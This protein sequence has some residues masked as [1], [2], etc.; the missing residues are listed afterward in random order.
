MLNSLVRLEYLQ[1][2]FR[3]N[4]ELNDNLQPPLSAK[5]PMLHILH[6]DSSRMHTPHQLISSLTTP[7]T[8]VHAHITGGC[9][10]S[11]IAQLMN[12]LCAPRNVASLRT[13]TLSFAIID[14]RPD[15]SAEHSR[16]GSFLELVEPLLRLHSLTSLAV[17]ASIQ[18]WGGIQ[19]DSTESVHAQHKPLAI[20]DFST[21]TMARAWPCLRQLALTHASGFLKYS[22]APFDISIVRPS[23]GALVKLA[24]ECPA[25]EA[26]T[27]HVADVDQSGLESLEEQVEAG[28]GQQTALLDIHLEGDRSVNPDDLHLVDIDRLATVLH[29]LFPRLRGRKPQPLP[30][31]ADPWTGPW[32]YSEIDRLLEKLYTL[33]IGTGAA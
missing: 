12:A 2:T 14:Q 28:C 22:V 9:Y 3:D 26:L 10:Y 32:K 23:I 1:V 6:I 21:D 13:L 20:D 17:H 15:S 18:P 19:H 29:R 27:M 16:P 30:S 5:F 11:E 8:R 25:L 33:S 31:A 7:L 24:Q 4:S